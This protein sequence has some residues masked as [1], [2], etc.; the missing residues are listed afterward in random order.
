MKRLVECVPNFS[1]G[2]RPEVVDQIVAAIQSAGGVSLLDKEMDSNHNR[3]VVTFVG[4]PD[5]CVEAAFRGCKKA[6]EL[7]DLT[8]H[9]GEHPRIG[10][11]D[12]CPFIPISGVSNDECVAMA[13]K[14][15]ARIAEELKIPTYLYELA[16]VRADRTDLAVIR[17]GEFE[18]LREDIRKNPDR[19][20]DFG[21]SELHPTAGASVVGARFPLVAYNVNLTTANV[22]IAKKIAKSLRF[23][24]GGFRYAKSMGFEIKE[25]NC[26][27]VSINMTNF[28]G[29]GLHRAFEFVKREAERYGVSV[30]ES[31][32]IGLVPQQAL[33]DAAVWYLQIDSFNNHQI[34]ETK[35]AHSGKPMT[36][37]LEELA[38]PTP[39][40]GGGSASALSGSIGASLLSMVC[41]LTAGKKG[42]EAVSAEMNERKAALD[43]MRGRFHALIDK[44]AAAFD[45]VMA[46]F[47]LAKGTDE[48]KA[49]RTAAIQEATKGACEAPLEVM[50]L[51]V[52]GLRHA[53]VVAEKGNKNSV[54]DA[55][56]G[57][58]HLE[59][60]LKGAALNVRINLPSLKDDSYVAEKK[61][62]VQRLLDEGRE[63]ARKI[64]QAVE[65]GM[66]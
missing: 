8:K 35:L 1:E 13:K 47:K 42:Y 39:T 65:K 50:T 6:S 43:P 63:L 25:K 30:L 59:T 52:E 16:A 31:E 61:L 62:K 22:D 14:L 5:S 26:A 3:A 58:M 28:T 66:A 20:P 64:E 56:V 40:P 34:L 21:P 15:A 36:D 46:A 49:K 37:W 18:G 48:E 12:V 44:D 33:I 54:T 23:K 51:A 53:L 29:T 32:I 11:M 10:A 45:K 19:K 4:D 55:G 9:Q 41:G 27:Q 2:R 24:D 7:I 38:A 57:A 60:A 17:K